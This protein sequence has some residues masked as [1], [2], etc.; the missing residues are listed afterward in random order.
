M[1]VHLHLLQFEDDPSVWKRVAIPR[2]RSSLCDDKLVE[3]ITSKGTWA[4]LE[5]LKLKGGRVSL[6][7]SVSACKRFA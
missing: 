4:Q 2:T 6:R 5:K 7:F 3:R 1:R